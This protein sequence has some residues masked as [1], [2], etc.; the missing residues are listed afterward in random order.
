[1]VCFH[2]YCVF[3]IWTL[4]GSLQHLYI[5]TSGNVEHCGTPSALHRW[6]RFAWF[7]PKVVLGF[8]IT[9]FI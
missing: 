6:F 9:I 4:H 1:M 5:N 2:V 3:T 7:D 8:Y